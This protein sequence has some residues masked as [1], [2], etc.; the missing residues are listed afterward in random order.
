MGTTLLAALCTVALAQAPSS[1]T[2][3]LDF[4][5]E[6][7]RL[8]GLLDT[9]THV[10]ARSLLIVV[11]GH[12]PTDVVAGQWFGTLRREMNSIGVATFAWDKPGCGRSQGEYDHQ[13]PVAAA[14]AEVRAAMHHMRELEVPG[15]DAIGFWGTS[16]GGWI[17][18]LVLAEEPDARFWISVSGTS[19]KE[20]FGYLLRENLRIE[21]RTEEEVERVYAEWMAANEVQHAGGTYEDARRVSPNLLA[22]PF[23]QEFFPSSEEG[24]LSYQEKLLN[25][26]P[27]FDEETGLF[28]H[29]EGFDEL[30]RGIT[31]PVLAIFGERDRNVDWRETRALYERTI[32]ARQPSLLTVET[33]PEGNHN[34]KQC[35]TGAWRETMATLN[36]AQPCDGYYEAMTAW[37]VGV[38]A[39]TTSR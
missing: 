31:S 33:F 10:E 34:L 2:E 21:G 25:S 11:P 22:D 4:E 20:N 38:G 28:V 24:Y 9:P 18:P 5:H 6:G 37:L 26:N 13:R 16:R 30:L 19:A 12:G 29:V 39:G 14:A 23:M 35:E 8:V 27:T 17:V 32:G 7:K 36:T 3:V 15:A 1:T